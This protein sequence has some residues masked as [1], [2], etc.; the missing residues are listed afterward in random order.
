MCVCVC[1]TAITDTTLVDMIFGAPN[2]NLAFTRYCY[3]CMAY[4]R[5]VGGGVNPELELESLALIQRLRNACEVAALLLRVRRE[6]PARQETGG[7][8]WALTRYCYYQ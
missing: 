8:E 7:R 4:K 1:W 2:P 3:W 5:E 6:V